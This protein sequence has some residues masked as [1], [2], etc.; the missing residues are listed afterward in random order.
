MSNSL[1]L[2]RGFPPGPVDLDDT[3]RAPKAMAH[4]FAG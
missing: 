1:T 3:K 2:M 4:A